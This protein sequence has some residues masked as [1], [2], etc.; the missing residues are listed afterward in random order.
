MRKDLGQNPLDALIPA[1][2]P[3]QDKSLEPVSESPRRRVSEPH[4]SRRER[5]TVNLPADVIDQ[6]RDACW[7]ERETLAGLVER[8]LRAELERIRKVRGDIPRRAEDL[9]PGRPLR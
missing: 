5:F 6:V 1:Q 7:W 2:E 8:S 9:K 3:P 4:P